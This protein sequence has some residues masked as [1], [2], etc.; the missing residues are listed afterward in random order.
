MLQILL[1]GRRAR[2]METH[3]NLKDAS[4]FHNCGR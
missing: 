4:W 1:L 2:L 3:F